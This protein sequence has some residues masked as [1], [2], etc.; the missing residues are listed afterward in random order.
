MEVYGQTGYVFTV[1]GTRMR[2]RLMDEKNERPV[3][4]AP[5]DTPAPDPFA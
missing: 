3:E 4:A 2:I 1:D 5:T